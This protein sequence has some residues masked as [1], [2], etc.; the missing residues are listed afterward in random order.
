MLETLEDFFAYEKSFD[1]KFLIAWTREHA[2][3]PI[4]ATALYLLF[5]FTVPEVLKKPFQLKNSFAMWN[6]F[7]SAFS[8]V[9]VTRCVPHL[10]GTLYREGFK[11]TVCH[12]PM[13][14]YS[15]GP[16]GLWMALFVYS[17][18]PELM[19]TV[20]LVL[21]KKPVIFLHW[22]HHVTVLLYCWH[23]FHTA[24]APGLWFA[25]MNF[26]V[27]SI[28]YFYFG[29]T[30][31]GFYKS[32][33]PLAPFIT[34]IQILQMVGGMICLSY[35]GY[36]QV[37]AGDYESC[38]VNPANWKLGLM[39]YFSYFVLFAVLFAQKY[40]VKKETKKKE[41][42]TCP[43]ECSKALDKADASGF[44]HPESPSSRRTGDVSAKS[45]EDELAMLDARR[46]EIEVLLGQKQS[47]ESKASDDVA[48]KDN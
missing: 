41:K 18:I 43:P 15:K 13:T 37:V 29:M 47:A 45:F 7:L 11:Y 2:E 5:I 25:A 24:V 30:N 26:S 17:K 44:F 12:D 34:T 14:W 16:V 22:F 48:K 36:T 4:L 27:H 6:F 32:M 28:M 8:I 38:T 9:G 21:R 3:L 10:L 23:A 20:F 40:L 19:D 35:I 39:M 42:P 31:I 46:K 1:G 33:Q